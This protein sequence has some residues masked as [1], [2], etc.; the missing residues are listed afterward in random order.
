[1]RNF[2]TRWV[3]LSVIFGVVG[4]AQAGV[5]KGSREYVKREQQLY[6]AK[7]Q[8]AK[9]E[10]ELR[11][12]EEMI[13]ELEEIPTVRVQ[14]RDFWSLNAVIRSAM[15]RELEQATGRQQD[16]LD[17]TAVEMQKIIRESDGLQYWMAEGDRDARTRYHHLLGSFRDLMRADLDAKAN[18][19]RDQESALV[20]RAE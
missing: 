1:M 11:D 5:V 9:E 7:K 15:E 4:S 20:G 13:G 17:E 14:S 3:I 10:Q 18:S 8:Q 6:E 16:T 12:F 19:I 2:A